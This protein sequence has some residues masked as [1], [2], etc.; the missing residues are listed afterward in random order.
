MMRE[1]AIQAL[2]GVLDYI[3]K[4]GYELSDT[5]GGGWAYVNE[6]LRQVEQYISA[7]ACGG[8]KPIARFTTDI[9]VGIL[10]V[11][12]PDGCPDGRVSILVFNAAE[13]G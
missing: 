6:R 4:Y 3:K 5:S 10:D 1:E 8:R 9:V 11:H 7:C 2:N 12:V 13:E